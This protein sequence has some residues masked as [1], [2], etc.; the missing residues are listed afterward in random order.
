MSTTE[1]QAK[2]LIIKLT[3]DDLLKKGNPPADL[4]KTEIKNFFKRSLEVL[5]E[6]EDYERCSKLKEFIKQFSK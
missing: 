3:V 5:E 2:Y 6:N 1:D 4:P